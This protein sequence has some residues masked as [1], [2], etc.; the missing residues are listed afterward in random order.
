MREVGHGT[1]MQGRR[2]RPQNSVYASSVWLYAY[3][4]DLAKTLEG[5]TIVCCDGMW[6]IGA[7]IA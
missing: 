6:G 3:T 7:L 5:G 2:A 1:C 4:S